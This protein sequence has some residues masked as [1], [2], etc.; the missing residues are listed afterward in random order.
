MRESETKIRKAYALRIF[1]WLYSAVHYILR[2]HDDRQDHGAAARGV[3]DEATEDVA[4][5]RLDGGPLGD[6]LIFALLE[7][8]EDAPSGGVHELLGFANVDEAAR[9]EVGSGDHAPRGAV[10]RHDDDDDAFARELLAVA[11]DDVADVAD[12]ETVDEHDARL[13]LA[14]EFRRVAREL[15]NATVFVEKDVFLG[16]AEA[17]CKL[18][19][20]HEHTVFAVNGHEVARANQI[21]HELQRVLAGMTR[22][23]DTLAPAVDDVGAELQQEVD[24]LADITLVAGDRRRRDD[25]GVHRRD[26]DLAM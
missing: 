8:T 19:M 5:G 15:K 12:A 20:A 2:F 21:V 11:Q 23:V 7:R 1:F 16:R 14:V 18:G 10:D 22:D 24:G 25:D 26:V 13:H 9:H 6:V 17:L 4:D 3:E